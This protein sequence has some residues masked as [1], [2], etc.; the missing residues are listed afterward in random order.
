MLHIA[1]REPIE[2][3][4]IIFLIIPISFRTNRSGWWE[5]HIRHSLDAVLV[6]EPV[7]VD[8]PTILFISK[9]EIITELN[10]RSALINLRW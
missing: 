6:E 2:L 7:S 8:I 3:R 4:R 5:R 9:L 1:G 10:E